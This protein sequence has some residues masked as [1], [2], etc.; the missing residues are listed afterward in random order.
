MYNRPAAASWTNKRE[1][2]AAVRLDCIILKHSSDCRAVGFDRISQSRWHC[3]GLVPVPERVLIEGS[4]PYSDEKN[5][6]L[7]TM[8]SLSGS[9]SLAREYVHI[10]YRV[11]AASKYTCIR[12]HSFSPF[13]LN[14]LYK[15][16]FMTSLLGTT[17]ERISA[18]C[19]T[20]GL[21]CVQPPGYLYLVRA[22]SCLFCYMVLAPGGEGMGGG[23]GGENLVLV[24][25]SKGDRLKPV[26]QGRSHQP[27]LPYFTCLCLSWTTKG[28][29][30]SWGI[31][32]S[33]G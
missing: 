29:P 32:H 25:K 9:G 10:M 24:C 3:S 15:R 7:S 31:P 8:I 17:M 6:N 11:S 23:G 16:H 19:T 21:C 18:L 30:S 22:I 5:H 4:R 12:L 33:R 13:P 2:V 14:I 1:G 26:G 28:V 27:R 20:V